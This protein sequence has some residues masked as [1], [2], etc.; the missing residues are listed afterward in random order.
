MIAL[1]A[2]EIA[3]IVGFVGVKR[4]KPIGPSAAIKRPVNVSVAF[5]SAPAQKAFSPAPVSTMTRA[6][7]SASKRVYASCNATAVGPSTAFRRS[8]RSMLTSAAAPL[9]S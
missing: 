6:S 2:A 3:A 4:V 9:R 7:S 5:R 8:W 1:S